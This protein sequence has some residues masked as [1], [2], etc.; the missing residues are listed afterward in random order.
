[1]RERQASIDPLWEEIVVE[2]LVQ[3][4]RLAREAAQR[5]VHGMLSQLGRAPAR[6]RKGGFRL[7]THAE[8]FNVACDLA[9]RQLDLAQFREQYTRILDKLTSAHVR[10]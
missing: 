3:F 4:H 1:M 5:Q 7:I 8:P 9:E 10:Q 2:C 6:V